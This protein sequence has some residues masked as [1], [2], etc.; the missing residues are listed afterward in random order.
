MKSHARISVWILILLGIGTSGIAWGANGDIIACIPHCSAGGLSGAVDI[1]YDTSDN[2]LWVLDSGGGTVCHY[3]LSALP[4][5]ISL[6]GSISHS[7]G[8]AA[9]PFFTPQVTGVAFNSN[10]NT[11][12]VMRNDFFSQEIHHMDKTGLPIGAPVTL[13][14]PDVDTNPVGLSFD[15]VTGNLWYRDIQNQ[16]LVECD[17]ATGTTVST[18]VIPGEIVFGTGVHFLNDG[19]TD[20][21]EITYGDVLDFRPVR[22]IRLD[23]SGNVIGKEVNLTQLPANAQGLVRPPVGEVIY[24]STNDTADDEDDIC[25][26]DATCPLVLPPSFFEARNNADGSISFAWLNHGPGAGGSYDSLRL[27]RNAQ[28]IQILPSGGQTS[29]TDNSPSPIGEV[30]IY[31]L[32][33]LVGGDSSTAVLEMQSGAGGLM[34]FKSFAGERPYGVALKPSNGQLYVTD[35]TT[36]DTIYFYDTDLNLLGSL[37]VNPSPAGNLRGLAYDSA[38]DILVASRADTHLLTQID[39]TTGTFISQFP[40]ISGIQ[41]GGVA[42]DPIGIAGNDHYL[43]MDLTNE[44]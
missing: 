22:V 1:A 14:P 43:L 23:L 30:I 42:Y 40:T 32:Q 9:P 29:F 20:Y 8:P 5:E 39:P 15:P 11:I 7:V 28:L 41:I 36:N 2:S 17:P 4:P 38:R 10:S 37:T 31:T 35:N 44:V 16:K 19:G 6:I 24:V 34:D 13:I 33:A 3:G 12:Y 21:L 27:F 18:I 25:K 26:V